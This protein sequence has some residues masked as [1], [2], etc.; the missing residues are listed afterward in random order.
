MCVSFCQMFKPDETLPLWQSGV[1]VS[2]VSPQQEGPGFE[3]S[4]VNVCVNAWS[5]LYVTPAMN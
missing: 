2:S 4:I 5:S 3:W 1:V